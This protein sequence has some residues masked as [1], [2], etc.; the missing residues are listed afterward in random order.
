MRRP[1]IVPGLVCAGLIVAASSSAQAEEATQRDFWSAAA[2]EA[3]AIIHA[4]SNA[5]LRRLGFSV[6]STLAAQLTLTM[7]CRD[8]WNVDA[9]YGDVQDGS[10][11]L[12]I[13]QATRDCLPDIGAGGPPANPSTVTTRDATFTIEYQGCRDS[14]PQ[15]TVEEVCAAQ[16]RIYIAFG[17]MPARGGKRPGYLQLDTL[18]LSRADISSVLRSLRP[19]R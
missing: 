10:Q 13:N 18:G 6:G 7:I 8:E 5:S 1:Q 3:T 12:E 15:D 16:R 19:V 2:K 4:P 14:G 17:K 9:A 11:S